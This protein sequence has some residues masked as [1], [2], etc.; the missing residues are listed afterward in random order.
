[1]KML[2][3]ALSMMSAA[4]CSTMTKPQTRHASAADSDLRGRA[5]LHARQPRALVSGPALVKHLETD[6]Q[7]A[8]TL[9]LSDD[10]GIGDR[11]CPCAAA[12]SESPIAVLT[13]G[14]RVTDLV[15]PSGKRICA[16]VKAGAMNVAWHA[17]FPAERPRATVELAMSGR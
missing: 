13:R 10:P 3:L 8:V 15:V 6:G 2:I 11:N 1:M 4:A 7:G 12:E 16:S 14:S 17:Q 5:P 9:Y